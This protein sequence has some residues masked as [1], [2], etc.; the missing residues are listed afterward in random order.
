MFTCAT[1][2]GQ[3]KWKNGNDDTKLYYSTS[4]VNESAVTNFG[5]IFVLKLIH[6]SPNRF[7]ST[8]TAYNVSLNNDGLRITCVDDINNPDAQSSSET[9]LISIGW[10]EIII[11]K[12]I[13]ISPHY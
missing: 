10:T 12:I 11:S 5:G 2:T 9:D 7:E 1:D 8:A 6:A 13:Y 3:L 4:Q